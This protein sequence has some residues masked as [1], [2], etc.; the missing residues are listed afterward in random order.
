ML[1]SK[2]LGHYKD[3]LEG[4][5]RSQRTIE[6]YLQDLTFFSKWLKEKYN[7]PAYLEDITLDDIEDFLRMLKDER[8][9]KAASRRRLL[10][11]IKM[12]YKFAHKKELCP[13]DVT[14]QVEPIKV[15][16]KERDYLTEE[17]VREF[18]GAVESRLCQVVIYTMFYAGLRVSE[19]VNLKVDDVNLE[20]KLIK[21][22]QGKGAKD[23]VVPINTKLLSVFEDYEKWRVDSE[24][25]FASEQTGKFSKVRIEAIV[26]ETRKRLGLEKQITPHTFRHSFASHLVK[27]QVNIVS[28]S[29]LMGHSDIKVTSVYTHAGLDMLE[30]AVAMM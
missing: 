29:K 18:V 1:L 16:P 23:R 28:I 9:Y 7:C 2:A 14:L 30:E 4:T 19:C 6:G 15:V 3:Y 17:E 22:V 5:D 24:Y 25:F 11:A 27:K 20:K 26:R 12:F 10:A 13:E 8:N 21:V